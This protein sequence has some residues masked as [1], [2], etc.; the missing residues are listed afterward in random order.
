VSTF[1]ATEAERFLW[2]TY[3]ERPELGDPV[4]RIDEVRAEIAETG[5]Y[6]HTTAELSHGARLAW[7]N[8]SRCIGRLYWNSLVVRDYRHIEDTA[9]VFDE[10]VAHLRVATNGGRIRPVVTVFAPDTPTR[11]GP[12]IRNDQ[13]IRYAGWHTP[14]LGRIGD[15]ITLDVTRAAERLGWQPTRTDFEVLPLIVDQADG[16]R[17]GFELPDDAVLQVPIT[18]PTLPWFAELGLRWYA[19]PAL[20]DMDLVIGGVTYGCAP[21]SGWYMGTEIGARN[22]ADV[23]RYDM[24]PT[25]GRRLGL[26]LSSERTLWRD[27]ALVELNVAVLHSYEQAGV[28]MTDHHTESERFLNHLAAEKRQGRSTPGNWSWLV[29]PISG[30]LSPVFHRYYDEN[31]SCPAFVKRGTGCPVHGD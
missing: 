26:D 13:L 5:T 24:L 30:S 28:T 6:T 4:P 25:I 11:R 17:E 16:L 2:E 9:G 10:C 1:V 22:L 19:V 18:H 3:A 20:S 27:R 21:F 15:P 12:R 31:E 23:Q 29:P 14:Q 8:N 7:R